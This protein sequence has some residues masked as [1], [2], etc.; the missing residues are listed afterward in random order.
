MEAISK[1]IGGSARERRKDGKTWNERYEE[2]KA[3]KESTSD[4]IG[5][6]RYYKWS[7]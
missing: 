6:E 5:K 4:E 2:R 1:N 3:K 7:Y